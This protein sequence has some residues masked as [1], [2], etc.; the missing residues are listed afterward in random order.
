[1][2]SCAEKVTAYS[3]SHCTEKKENNLSQSLESFLEN[4][5][6]GTDVM[7]IHW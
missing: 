3:Q 7:Y 5:L 6:A 2:S 1:M 4:K